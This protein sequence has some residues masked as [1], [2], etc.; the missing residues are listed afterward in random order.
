MHRSLHVRTGAGDAGPSLRS[1]ERRTRDSWAIHAP[2]S[3]YRQD[4]GIH[5]PH[6]NKTSGSVIPSSCPYPDCCRSDS[7]RSRSHY[8]RIR[9]SAE[10]FPYPVSTASDPAVHHTEDCPV[11]RHNCHRHPRLRPVPPDSLWNNCPYNIPAPPPKVN[12]RQYAAFAYSSRSP[13][14]HALRIRKKEKHRPQGKAKVRS[15]YFVSW[16]RIPYLSFMI[17]LARSSRWTR[18]TKRGAAVR[19]V[20]YNLFLAVRYGLFSMSAKWILRYCSTSS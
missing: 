3:W 17:C 2:G 5:R 8:P 19:I 9:H 10:Y 15:T 16:S 1:S 4:P 12:C 20:R 7:S 13:Y 14:R 18:R 6:R 11:R